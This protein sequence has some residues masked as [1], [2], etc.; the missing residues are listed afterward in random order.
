MS[1]NA[2]FI[3]WNHVLCKLN[4]LFNFIYLPVFNTYVLGDFSKHVVTSMRGS[5][6]GFVS[7]IG[8]QKFRQQV[9]LFVTFLLCVRACVRACVCVCV[10]FLFLAFVIIIYNGER[11]SEPIF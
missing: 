2:S 8:G 1:Y 5:M 10:V 4:N 3:I 9:R 11:G 7:E 6:R